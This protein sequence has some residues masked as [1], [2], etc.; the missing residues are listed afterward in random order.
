MEGYYQGIRP[1][2]KERACGA[3][4]D[5][6]KQNKTICAYYSTGEGESKRKNNG[7]D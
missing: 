1:M 4:S 2:Q 7:E 3:G 6:K 5:Q